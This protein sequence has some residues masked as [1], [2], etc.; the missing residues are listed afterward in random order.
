MTKKIEEI[1]GA[2]DGQKLVAPETLEALGY[3]VKYE[4]ADSSVLI[5]VAEEFLT[6]I[7][8]N[9]SD[10]HG[11]KLAPNTKE[12][13]ISGYLNIHASEI[14]GQGQAAS[15]RTIPFGASLDGTISTHGMSVLG[16]GNVYNDQFKRTQTALVVPWDLGREQV[17]VGDTTLS[18]TSALSYPELSGIGWFHKPHPSNQHRDI[19]G[20]VVMIKNRTTL[21]IFKNEVLYKVIEI[22]P[23]NF[24]ISDIPLDLGQNVV[25][26][27]M[28]DQV[29]GQITDK[30]ITDFLPI[31][32]VPVG[33]FESG[34]SYGSHRN[35]D[36][37]GI[38]YFGRPVAYA[39]AMYGL[40]EVVNLGGSL[41]AAG[42]Y[43]QESEAIR[44]FQ[45]EGNFAFSVS[46]SENPQAKGGAAT[47]EYLRS[48]VPVSGVAS[49]S[50]SETV[51]SG[52]YYANEFDTNGQPSRVTTLNVGL[53]PIKGVGLSF[54]GLDIVDRTSSK[55]RIFA[56]LTKTYRFSKRWG[57]RFSAGDSHA[58]DGGDQGHFA[59][60][61]S[62]SP[63]LD[64]KVLTNLATVTES[65]RGVSTTYDDQKGLNLRA[66]TAQYNG[67][68]SVETRLQATQSY[69]HGD[70]G[71]SVAQSNG[72]STQ[73]FELNTALVF[74]NHGFAI[75]EPLQ[76]SFVL[77]RSKN[78]RGV[79]FDVSDSNGTRIANSGSFLRSV[80]V[81]VPDWYNSE[82]SAA[83]LDS[84]YYTLES[85]KTIVFESR[86]R[87]GTTVSLQSES[88]AIVSG[89][90]I[91]ED[92][93]KLKATFL[94]FVC[95]KPDDLL[96]DV[97]LSDQNGEFQFQVKRFA[98]CHIEAKGKGSPS[99][100]LS[101]PVKY[102]DLGDVLMK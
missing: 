9:A 34:I 23:G 86:F 1:K 25:R 42:A 84:E 24:Q 70:I 43:V 99:L 65:T 44:Y 36:Y 85:S 33:S 20:G 78:D 76:S 35:E 14:L 55:D 51:T 89:T 97:G 61:L 21:Q 2:L 38:S 27:V 13:F 53:K 92:G 57:L 64:G 18:N 31:Y 74:T 62:Y 79:L 101:W 39:G 69:I 3:H 40:N 6:P 52:G 83:F 16:G 81:S 50:L 73:E 29:T 93:K 75:S 88:R 7:N 10:F 91:D 41:Y 59:I 72:L 47:L 45:N 49:I 56:T 22:G 87:T 12:D 17:W 90:L 15:G 100:D 11:S 94:K 80:A 63:Y 66:S 82:H 30:T 98:D 71:A 58:T 95:S 96:T 19:D 37:L 28:R 54:G 8:V 4:T 5:E 60:E 48:L 67:S 68:E 46:Q 102:K 77:I 32:S 26:L